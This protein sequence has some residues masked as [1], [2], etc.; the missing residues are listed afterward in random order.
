MR[1]IFCKKVS[2]ASKSVEHIIPES[3]GNTK[4]V[5]PPGVVCDSCNNYFSREVEKP[6]LESPAVKALRF[7][8][9]ISSKKGKI[10]PIEGMLDPGIPVTM[11]RYLKG[12]FV[13]S[14]D[15]NAEAFKQIMSS[16]QGRVIFP[17]SG[18]APK[19]LVVSRFLAKAG[20]EVV[21][22]RLLDHPE[23]LEYLVDEV[24][25]DPVRNHA[26][27]GDIRQWPHYARRIYDANKR[28]DD[29]TD[30]GTQVMHE[31][32][33]LQTEAGELYF[34]VAIFGLELTL[35]MSGPFIDGYI[36][37][38]KQHNQISPLYPDK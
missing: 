8:Q 16:D 12:P 4:H 6:F 30:T 28:W 20:M 27:R 5:L 15:V 13:G 25:F 1:C 21:A 29:G 32:D 14:I 35:N 18:E 22:F 3:I 38:I 33:F 37:W 2:D 26:R 19:D 31:F 24:Q 23:G 11:Y 36:D 17:L 10:P 34:V 9:G 7:H